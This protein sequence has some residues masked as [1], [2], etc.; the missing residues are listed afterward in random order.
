MK[1]LFHSQTSSDAPL[2]FGNE[3]VNS[4]HVYRIYNYL[5]TLAFNSMLKI[6]VSQRSSGPGSMNTEPFVPAFITHTKLRY[7]EHILCVMVRIIYFICIMYEDWHF[8]EKHLV[9]VA[10]WHYYFVVFEPLRYITYGNIGIHCT[11]TAATQ[12]LSV[13]LGV[14]CACSFQYTFNVCMGLLPDT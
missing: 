7:L 4:S 12:W 1:L 3:F 11:Y 6:Y 9:L 5:S 14:S 13:F 8:Y 2:K 10:N